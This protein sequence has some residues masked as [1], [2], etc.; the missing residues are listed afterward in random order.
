MRLEVLPAQPGAGAAHKGECVAAV[1]FGG[2]GELSS[3]GDDKHVVR[4]AADGTPQGRLL[5]QELE[6]CVTCL[7]WLPAAARRG[8][9]A[10][11]GG[12][13]SQ[14]KAQRLKTVV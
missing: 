11:G 7:H 13:V 9:G 12:A 5:A 3:A 6:A 4:W 1:G 2:G 14:T 10:G 8:G